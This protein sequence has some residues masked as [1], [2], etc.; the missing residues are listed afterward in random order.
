MLPYVTIIF[1]FGRREFQALVG[2]VWGRLVDETA[3]S[4]KKAISSPHC[5][6]LSIKQVTHHTTFYIPLRDSYL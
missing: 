5:S 4:V 3:F 2:A 1:G 6:E